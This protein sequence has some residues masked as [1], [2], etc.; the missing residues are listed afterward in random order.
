M[1]RPEYTREEIEAEV[2]R[3]A[4]EGRVPFEDRPPAPGSN[5]TAGSEEGVFTGAD[6]LGEELGRGHEY[7]VPGTS[8]RLWV[9]GLGQR[10]LE[11]L[12]VWSLQTLGS[13]EAEGLTGQQ[14]RQVQFGMATSVFQAIL[15]CRTGPTRKHPRCFERS[16]YE[17]VRANLGYKVIEEIVSLSSAL[18]GNDETLGPGVRRF[19]G[20][21]LAC[22]RTCASTSSGCTDF[23]AG[24]QDTLT[25][26]LSLASRALSRGSLTSGMLSEL[27][28][29]ESRE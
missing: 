8:K 13:G 7:V 12:T 25:R 23:P 22:L 19:F 29:L 2:R 21:M 1:D 6:L 26:L 27:D 5:G 4:I 10:D 11:R 20:T 14:A 24:W 17:A 3:A 18:S 9:F 28:A 16:H 15:C